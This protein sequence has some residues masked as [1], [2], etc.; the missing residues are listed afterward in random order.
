MITNQAERFE[1][2]ISGAGPAQWFGPDVPDGDRGPWADA[3]V[4][5]RY[6]QKTA[7]SARW[8][9]KRKSDGAD[10]DWALTWGEI[11]ETVAFT[12]FTDGGAA[13]GTYNLT[14]TIPAGAWVLRSM[15]RNVTGF[16]G[17]TSAVITVGDGDGG[18]ST[19]VD[20]Y[21]T[22]TPSVF[23]TATAVDLGAPSGTQVH[24]AAATVRLAVTTAS[25]WGKVTAGR[26][27]ISIYFV[28]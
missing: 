19:D 26:L 11:R 20:R 25:D 2:G 4:G 22:G 24:T 27:T 14:E 28:G 21:N 6:L 12:D 16:A 8:Y 23:A 10:N 3:P 7:T 15:L 13:V 17:D 1:S 18:G 5:S 9:E